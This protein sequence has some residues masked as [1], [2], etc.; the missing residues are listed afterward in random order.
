[1]ITDEELV[2]ELCSGI[3]DLSD[4]VRVAANPHFRKVLAMALFELAGEM[5]DVCNVMCEDEE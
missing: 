1:M 2:K 3:R 5:R 4:E